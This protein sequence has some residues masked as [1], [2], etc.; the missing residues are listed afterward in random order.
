[1]QPIHSALRQ[2]FLRLV[3]NEININVAF[4]SE[5]LAR[6]LSPL[7]CRGVLSRGSREENSVDKGMLTRHAGKKAGR[8]RGILILGR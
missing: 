8:E 3:V 4:F 1:M 6:K 5:R 2:I 7:P